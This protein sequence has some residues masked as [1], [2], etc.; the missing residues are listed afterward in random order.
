VVN[1]AL[2]TEFPAIGPAM[3]HAYQEL[4]RAEL[5]KFAEEVRDLG[6]L[7]LLPRP[8]DVTTIDDPDLR[9]E[10]WEWL[11]EVVGWLNV[12]YMWDVGDLIP[13]CWPSHPH[14]VHELGVVADQRRRAGFAFTS[15]ALEEWHRYT[16]PY[17]IDRMR[18]RYRG[19]CEEGHQPAPGLSRNRRYSSPNQAEARQRL[20]AADAAA[21]FADSQDEPPVI[22]PT[23]GR[24]NRLIEGGRVDT[25]TGEITDYPHG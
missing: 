1:G 2:V 14:L 20:Y 23:I 9:L 8:W 25:A 17:F 19:F 11:D 3:S 24:R 22:E 16:L 13:P 12:E 21:V 18:S 7:E 15:D 4:F 5:A 10:V 6:P